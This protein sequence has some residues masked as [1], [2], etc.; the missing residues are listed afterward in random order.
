MR[1]LRL[2]SALISV[3][4]C[5]ILPSFGRDFVHSQESHLKL[6]IKKFHLNAIEKSFSGTVEPRCIE[7]A[8]IA[9]S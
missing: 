9:K 7:L 8:Y 1:D 3:I 2:R 6:R 4:S 5:D